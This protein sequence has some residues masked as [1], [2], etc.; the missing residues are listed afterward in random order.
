MISDTSSNTLAEAERAPRKKHSHW[1]IVS[2]H[3]LITNEVFNHRYNGSGTDEDP[4]RVEFIP[5]DPRD[6]MGFSM[7][8]KWAITLL[9]AFATLA[10]AFV[11]SAYTGGVEQIIISLHTSDEI[12]ILGVSLFVLGVSLSAIMQHSMFTD[13]NGSLQLALCFG[14]LSLSF[15]AVRFCILPRMASLLPS[16]L[17]PPEL[18]VFKPYLSS[19]SLPALSVHLLSRM[20]VV[21]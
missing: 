10:V 7:W 16:M 15:M 9:V 13:E 11:S 6:P 8:K 12:V 4:Y 17:G 20:L 3:A 19:V 5:N 21:S 18:R 14:P 2:S 1:N